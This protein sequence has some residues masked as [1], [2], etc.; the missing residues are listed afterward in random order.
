MTV[1]LDLLK[2]K[3]TGS[4]LTE[5]DSGYAE[6]RRLFN[7][8]I[9]SRPRAI[10][11]CQNVEDVCIA[12]AWAKEAGWPLS[13]RGGGHGVHGLAIVDGGVVLDLRAMNDVTMDLGTRRARVGGGARWSDVYEKAAKHDLAPTGGTETSVGVAGFTMGS[14]NA[15][16]MRRHGLAC[17]NVLAFEL[18]A[19]DGRVIEVDESEPEL[20]WALKGGG[21][22][23]GVVTAM[24]LQLHSVPT[25]IWAGI[26]YFDLEYAAKTLAE[27]REIMDRAT[28]DTA[29]MWA[30]APLPDDPQ[31]PEVLRGRNVVL[32]AMMHLGPVGEGQDAL[33]ALR[34]LAPPLLDTVAE[35]PF[36]LGIRVLD[37]VAPE[38]LLNYWRGMYL[39]SLDDVAI[40]TTLPMVTTTAK[41]GMQVWRMGGAVDDVPEAST[42]IPRRGRKYFVG[43]ASAWIDTS[44]SAQI[45]KTTDAAADAFGPWTAGVCPNH[46][47]RLSQ[48]ELRAALGNEIFDRLRQVKRMIDPKNIFAS[49]QNI[50]P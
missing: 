48:G 3:L 25:R 41:I 17:D 44:C 13:V 34:Q 27:Y 29:A 40:E 5:G 39:R 50:E 38:G 43:L 4:L 9:S 6:A 46:V 37:G 11:R 31:L 12:I 47:D 23:F 28:R 15:W 26:T 2:A 1:S 22:N 32:I 21:G 18:V 42:A 10:I 33:K 7:A 30:I 36:G 24:T 35:V 49:N 19:P 14:G 16:L 45:I 20:F 8:R